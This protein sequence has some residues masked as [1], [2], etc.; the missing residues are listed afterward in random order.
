M[1]RDELLL[2][3]LVRCDSMDKGI[4]Q[5]MWLTLTSLLASFPPSGEF[6]GHI[7]AWLLEEARYSEADFCR[8]AAQHCR[9]VMHQ[10]IFMY[11]NGGKL[12]ENV[13]GAAL[14]ILAVSADRIDGLWA[15]QTSIFGE[16][17]VAPLY[18]SAYYDESSTE[19]KS[20]A[21]ESEP[22]AEYVLKVLANIFDD[23]DDD[24]SDGDN[25]GNKVDTSGAKTPSNSESASVQ[26]RMK[27]VVG[28]PLHGWKR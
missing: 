15:R 28:T 10:S 1:M 24:S 20:E 5:A 18:S 19:V 4:Q 8:K 21:P 23:D 16:N 7:E 17:G 12:P 11:G 25:R 3:A 26:A 14:Q 13:D 27:Y 6:E 22:E 2:L 9:D